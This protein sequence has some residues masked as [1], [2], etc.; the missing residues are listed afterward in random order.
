MKFKYTRVDQSVVRVS[1]LSSVLCH[2]HEEN[3][4]SRAQIASYIGLNKSTVSSLANELIERQLVHETGINAG[5]RGRP[6]TRLEI[7]PYAGGIVGV[8]LGVDFVSVVLTDFVGNIL[9]Q[10][11]EEVGSVKDIDTTVK[12]SLRIIN[13]AITECRKINLRILGLGLALPGIVDIKEGVLVLAPNLNWH[14]VP[15][16]KICEENT[17]LPVFVDNDANAAAIGE[18]LFGA[19]RQVRDFIFVY[20]GIGIGGGLFL[21]NELYRGKNGFAGEFGHAPIVS[22]SFRVPNH[23]DNV[24]DW[25][26]HAC[27]NSI[28]QRVQ[29]SLQAGYKSII[30]SSIKK[31]ETTLSLHLIKEAADAG[32][33]VALD[34]FAD[35]GEAIGIGIAN[36]VNT[37]NPE[38]VIIG[39]PLS[40]FGNYLISPIRASVE[41]HSFPEISKH[42]EIVNSDFGENACVIGA[43]SLVVNDI[44]SNPTHSEKEVMKATK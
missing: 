11:T 36:L 21:K 22:D 3:I 26:A 10:K 4:L 34:A 13:G 35:T 19:G 2:L 23:E 43:V 9:W 40:A 25:E 20:I 24:G 41:K 15:F 12:Q 7:N 29:A 16:R 38:K 6:A 44:L 14:N 32:D 37:F 30:P 39:G 8:E 28:I 5:N 33:K 42:A 31:Q 18:H 1:N 27:Q 17:G